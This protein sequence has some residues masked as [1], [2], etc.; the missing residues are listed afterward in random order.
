MY[1][2]VFRFHIQRIWGW[3]E[4]WQRSNFSREFES[5]STTVVEVAGRTAGYVQTDRESK[6]LYLRNIALYPDIQGQ[7]I[8]TFLIEQLQQESRECGVPLELVL[9]RTNPRARELYERLGFKQTGQTDAFV[10]MSWH[11]A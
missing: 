8:G 4:E 9:F 5:S 7:G 6:R 2:T 3:N 11:A 10:K 1:R